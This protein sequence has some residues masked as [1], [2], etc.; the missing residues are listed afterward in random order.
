MDHNILKYFLALQLFLVAIKGELFTQEEKVKLKQIHDDCVKETGIDKSV[1][2]EIIKKKEYPD[3]EKLK[4]HLLCSSKKLKFMT[5]DGNIDKD[6]ISKTLIAKFKQEK[7][8]D[9]IVK[10]CAV[11][12]SNLLDTAFEMI[13]CFHQYAPEELDILEF[14]EAN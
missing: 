11:T 14:F 13:K 8:V 7:I 1:L 3:N 4:E 12:K 10:T 2:L 5:E 6:F 9:D